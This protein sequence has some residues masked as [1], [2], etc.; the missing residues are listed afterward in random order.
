MVFL[1][2]CRFGGPQ[3]GQPLWEKPATD[4]LGHLLCLSVG[5]NLS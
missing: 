3:V 4:I 2:G 5:L 1:F